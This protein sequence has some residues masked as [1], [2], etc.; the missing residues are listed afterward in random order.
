MNLVSNISILVVPR[1][2]RNL[3]L[4][5]MALLSLCYLALAII[6]VL[7]QDRP[8]WIEA[9]T[10]ILGI[11]IPFL[12]IGLLAAYSQSGVEALVAR[13]ARFLDETI[14]ALCNL[15]NEPVGPYRLAGKQ[16]AAPRARRPKV[17]VQ[18]AQDLAIANYIVL[19]RPQAPFADPDALALRRIP[20]R[21]ELNADKANVNILLDPAALKTHGMA[22]SIAELFPHSTKGAAHEGYWFADGFIER[23]LSGQSYCAAV[24]VKR[25][26]PE[27]LTS[28]VARLAFGQDLILML[29][30]M[31]AEQPS[32]FAK[33]EAPDDGA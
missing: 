21:I 28:P 29:R 25:L 16:A 24:A 8:G 2:V 15:F 19:A 6:G 22:K 9:G 31:L 13:T 33:A 11:L 32:L 30:A 5:I 14:P 26:P 27:F 4:A 12:L 3:V 23:E 18:S 17:Y 10:Y 7:D 20:F 1:W